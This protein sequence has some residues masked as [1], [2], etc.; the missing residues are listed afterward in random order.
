MA[1][2][3]TLKTFIVASFNIAVA[4]LEA[5]IEFQNFVVALCGQQ[6][7]I[8]ILDQYFIEHAQRLGGAVVE[9][10]ELLYRQLV[11]VLEAPQFS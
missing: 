6:V 4:H 3:S 5:A 10:H 11:P 7:L 8:K 9:L 2:G 1:E